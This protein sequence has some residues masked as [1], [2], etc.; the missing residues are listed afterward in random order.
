MVMCVN[1]ARKYVE[2]ELKSVKPKVLCSMCRAPLDAV[3][4]VYQT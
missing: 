3:K 4:K 1:C 2:L